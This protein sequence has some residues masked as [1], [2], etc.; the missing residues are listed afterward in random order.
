VAGVSGGE[1]R[2]RLGDKTH[3][4]AIK[5]LRLAK[6]AKKSGSKKLLRSSESN[7]RLNQKKKGP[8]KKGGVY[9]GGRD[10]KS[11]LWGAW[12]HL[13]GKC[14]EGVG[15]DEGGFRGKSPGSTESKT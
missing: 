9:R 14:K 10:V 7:K 1:N 11:S 2:R 4:Q 3:Q 13:G 6:Q 15:E 12:T 8:G 5:R